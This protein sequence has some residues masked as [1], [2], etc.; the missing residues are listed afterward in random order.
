MRVFHFLLGG[1]FVLFALL[2]LND[3]DPLLW[4]SIYL[5]AAVLCV[6]HGRGKKLIFAN[7][8]LLLCCVVYALWLF[9]GKDGVYSWFNE[10]QAENLVQTMKATKPWIEQTREFG[11][12]MIIITTSGMHLFGAQKSRNPSGSGHDNIT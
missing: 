2:Q 9:A 5:V 4:V 1:L 7:W 3:P 6:Q 8:A 11:G 10:H 12:L